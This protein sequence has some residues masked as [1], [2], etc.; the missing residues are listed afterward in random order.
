M[1]TKYKFNDP[2]GMYFV[3]FAFVAWVVVFMRQM[4]RDIFCNSVKYCHEIFYFFLVILYSCSPNKFLKIDRIDL[5]EDKYSAI[6]L[7]IIS[8][9]NYIYPR[10]NQNVFLDTIGDTRVKIEKIANIY[11]ITCFSLTDTITGKMKLLPY[12]FIGYTTDINIETFVDEDIL[13]YKFYRFYRI[14]DWQF[15]NINGLEIVNYS[16]SIGKLKKNRF[17][18]KN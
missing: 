1:S 14:E 4:C 18:Y 15:K 6:G 13:L 17:E 10:F 9:N 5:N 7:P 16:V 3:T 2:K 11:N 12:E 8:S